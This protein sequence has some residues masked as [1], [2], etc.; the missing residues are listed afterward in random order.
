MTVTQRLFIAGLL[1]EWD[2]A[3]RTRNRERMIDLLVTVGLVY[4]AEWF[5]DAILT[6]LILYSF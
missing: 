1:P 4:Q 6:N 3:A 5:A 2:T